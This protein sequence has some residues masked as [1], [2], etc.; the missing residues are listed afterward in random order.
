M[1]TEKKQCKYCKIELKKGVA[2]D[3]TDPD[4]RPAYKNYDKGELIRCWKCPKCGYSE[5]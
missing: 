1:K 5:D 2:L 4:C 3:Y